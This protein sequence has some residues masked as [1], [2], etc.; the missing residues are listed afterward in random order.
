MSA[1]IYSGLSRPP[2]MVGSANDESHS[3]WLLPVAVPQVVWVY[4]VVLPPLDAAVEA[5]RQGL[6]PGQGIDAVKVTMQMANK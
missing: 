2:L 1:A 5:I 6:A 4:G 3:C